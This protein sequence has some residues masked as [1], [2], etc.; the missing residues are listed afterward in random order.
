MSKLFD[1]GDPVAFPCLRNLWRDRHHQTW[2]GT[3]AAENARSL[4]APLN[5]TVVRR[6]QGRVNLLVLTKY[7]STISALDFA[8]SRVQTVLFR[9]V[10][11]W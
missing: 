6:G 10:H 7:H 11:Y 3:V 1:S 2:E 5:P 9:N 8:S 4:D